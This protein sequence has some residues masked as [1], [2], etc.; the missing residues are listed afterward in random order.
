M[1]EVTITVKDSK[2]KSPFSKLK[3]VI[4]GLF[5]PNIGMEF[6]CSAYRTGSKGGRSTNSI[7]RYYVKLG[8]EVIWDFPK[9]FPMIKAGHYGY[10]AAN[11]GICDLVRAYIDTPSGEI[12]SRD[13]KEFEIMEYEGFEY[14]F[15]YLLTFMFNVADRRVGKGR[16][17]RTYGWRIDYAP[18]KK[19]FDARFGSIYPK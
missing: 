6:C 8:K 4:E 9:D 13:F 5:D 19:I 15:C 12:L 17:L 3:K 11:N 18:A 16:L 7:P 1:G 10:W 2:G 14:H